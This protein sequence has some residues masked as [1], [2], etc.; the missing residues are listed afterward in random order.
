MIR[1]LF[2]MALVFM[3]VFFG[4]ACRRSTLIPPPPASG[5]SLTG[6]L[7]EAPGCGYDIVK[8][9]SG[10][11]PD[12]SVV[13]SWTD[14][15]S[16]ATFTNVFSV[17]DYILFYQDKITVGDTFTFTLNGP[18]P[19]SLQLYY[20]CNIIPYNVPSVWNNVTNIKLVQ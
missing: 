10:S 1:Y 3:I 12:S 16:G 20:G 13:K 14:S 4:L 19:D 6:T 18:V 11:Y 9:V 17:K 2:A 15:V 5:D 8:I 7:V